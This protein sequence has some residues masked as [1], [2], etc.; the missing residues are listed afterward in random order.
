MF[1]ACP[2]GTY[3]NNEGIGN[4]SACPLNSQSSSGAAECR[5]FDGYFRSDPD[6]VIEDCE[7]LPDRVKN[8]KTNR[9]E[10]TLLVEWDP[11][12]GFSRFGSSIQYR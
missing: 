2:T 3:K 11:P 1:Q 9:T 8:V 5:C 6:S 4:C 7:A 10:T 12:T